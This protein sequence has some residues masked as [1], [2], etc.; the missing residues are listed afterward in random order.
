VAR[1]A[2]LFTG[3]PGDRDVDRDAVPPAGRATEIGAPGGCPAGGVDPHC[4][5]A[6][7]RATFTSLDD[8]SSARPRR[9]FGGTT[10][11]GLAYRAG[12]APADVG[13]R[14]GRGEQGLCDRPCTRAWS[15][16]TTPPPTSRLLSATASSRRRCSHLRARAWRMTNDLRTMT[17]CA[18]SA[19]GIIHC[20]ATTSSRRRSSAAPGRPGGRGQHCRAP[21]DLRDSVGRGG[22]RDRRVGARPCLLVTVENRGDRACR[23]R[24]GRGVR[25]HETVAHPS[26]STKRYGRSE[27]ERFVCCPRCG[28][29]RLEGLGR[30]LF[31]GRDHDRQDHCCYDLDRNAHGGTTCG[32]CR[33][34][35][36]RGD[37][38]QSSLEYVVRRGLR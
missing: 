24:P 21:S 16:G 13:T 30:Q 32:R 34:G 12:Q 7:P 18:I 19:D 6:S 10:T 2:N 8:Y 23:Q 28:R 1:A 33:T 17:C 37:R 11:I 26:C 15:P 36:R 14:S 20:E 4:H 29:R 38:L 31:T 9:C 5:V 3:G 27:P 35:C 25:R 22:A